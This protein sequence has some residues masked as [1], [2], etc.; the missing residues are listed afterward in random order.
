MNIGIGIGISHFMHFAE[1][2]RKLW[3]INNDETLYKNSYII[4]FDWHYEYSFI[5]TGMSCC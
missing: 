2:S 1:Y 4:I 3:M 5:G